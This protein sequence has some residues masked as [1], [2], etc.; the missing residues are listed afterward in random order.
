MEYDV[1][2]IVCNLVIGYINKMSYTTTSFLYSND[3]Y[4]IDPA[5]RTSSLENAIL[6]KSKNIIKETAVKHISN[7]FLKESH[8]ESE[9]LYFA[10]NVLLKRIYAQSIIYNISPDGS[11]SSLFFDRGNTMSKTKYFRKTKIW[12]HEKEFRFIVSLGGRL[13]INIGKDCIKNI[14]L[15]CNM[16]NEKIIAIAYLMAQNNLTAGLYKMKRLK[17]CGLAPQRIKWENH[18]TN[19]NSLERTLL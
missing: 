1:D 2:K 17:N 16:S 11:P 13:Q 12:S 14:Y 8:N 6:E 3:K 18:K 19:L 7:R 15:G 4:N 9:I 10:R 5:L